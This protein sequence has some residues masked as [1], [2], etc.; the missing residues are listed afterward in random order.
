MAAPKRPR[1][2]SLAFYPKKRAKR[3]YPSV[4]GKAKS[5]KTKI[6]QFSVYKVGMTSLTILDTRKG[7]VTKNEE[8]RVPATIVECPPIKV[9]GI[10]FYK[11][12]PEGLKVM[13]EVWD[14]NS[15]K[16]KDLARKLKIGEQRANEKLTYAEQRIDQVKDISLIVKTNPKMTGLGKKKPEV[17]EIDIGG[18]DIKDKLKFAKDN[19]GK[20]IKINDVFKE[21]EYVDVIGITKGKGTQG[22][23][24]RYGVKIQFR[25][26]MK[27]HRQIGTLGSQSP[28]RIRWTVP[29]A[30]QLGFF[31]RTE[32][33]KRIL[34]I[35]NDGKEINPKG[36]I[37]NYGLV[38]STYMLI[39]GS[40]PGPKN[41][42]IIIRTPVRPKKT[43]FLPTEIRNIGG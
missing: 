34:K 11:S 42:L 31:Q 37:K 24:K 21:G 13:T 23:V 4:R 7:S 33:N 10:R 26:D 6:L 2:G 25:K 8:I 36:G 29:R 22:V 12:S 30:G 40:V 19:L 17:F 3:I 39:E 38:K 9:V 43:S 20:E 32:F 35:S 41:R 1:R 5:E 14:L 27:H 16:D 28:G 15:K 18:N